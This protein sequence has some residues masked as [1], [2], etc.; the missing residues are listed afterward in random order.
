MFLL[1]QFLNDIVIAK[2]IILQK[3]ENL[4]VTK[5]KG[6]DRSLLILLISNQDFRLIL[7][8]CKTSPSAR[9]YKWWSVYI[10]LSNLVVNQST[11]KRLTC[12]IRTRKAPSTK[13]TTSQPT[14]G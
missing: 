4:D 11:D 7:I 10:S 9:R 1:C 12:L 13:H 2:E 6:P 14:S 3:L 8:G 5:S